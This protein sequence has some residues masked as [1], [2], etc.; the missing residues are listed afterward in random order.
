MKEIGDLEVDH[1][2]LE[3][4]QDLEVSLENKIGT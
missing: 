3:V 4:N 2:R 1:R